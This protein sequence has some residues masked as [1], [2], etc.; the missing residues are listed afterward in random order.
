MECGEPP[1][2]ADGELRLVD[3]RTTYGARVV[4][5]CRDNYTLVGEATQ[6]CSDQVGWTGAPP[7]C[8]FDWCPD[9]PIV[10]GATV[11]TSSH[12][13]GAVATYT[14]QNGFILFGSPVSKALF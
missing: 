5:S 1:A 9:P 14:C 10:S 2:I 12:K 6:E 8:L 11:A 3:G 7:K 4:Y 13:A